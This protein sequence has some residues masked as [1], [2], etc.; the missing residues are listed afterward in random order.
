M[1]SLFVTTGTQFPFDRLLEL[2]E[3]WAS[4]N[5]STKIIAQTCASQINFKHIEAYE[6]LSPQKYKEVITNTKVI[7]G[8][9]GMGTIITAHENSLPVII[10][11]RRLAF[12]EHRNDHQ[13]ATVA[14]FKNTKGVYVADDERSLF[15]LLNNIENLEPCND[16]VPNNRHE[17]IEYLKR[18]I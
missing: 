13:M 9:A 3:E 6:F 17:L 1:K 2:V 12:E 15:T 18:A 5:V 14:K 11:P 16:K 7:I 4:H 10:M 8:H